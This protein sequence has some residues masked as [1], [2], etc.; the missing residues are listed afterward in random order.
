MAG[1]WLELSMS[2][3]TEEA[4]SVVWLAEAGS[5]LEIW[6]SEVCKIDHFSPFLAIFRSRILSCS[7]R[8]RTDGPSLATTRVSGC[9]EGSDFGPKRGDF[10]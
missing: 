9:V 10:G 7:F 1:F 3:T 6:G 5:E 8:A 2:W 4:N